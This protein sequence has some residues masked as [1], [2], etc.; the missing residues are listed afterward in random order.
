[1]KQYFRLVPVIVSSL[2]VCTAHSG[3]IP[4]TD[5]PVSFVGPTLEARLTNRLVEDKAYSLEGEAASRNLRVSG[6]Y[7]WKLTEC[8][9]LKITA[10]YLWQNIAY[11][12]FSGNSDVW[13]NQL[14]AGF[15]Y[16][17]DLSNS[18]M[19]P[20]LGL[21]AYI[22]HVPSKSLGSTLGSYVNS[23]G[24][25]LFF[26]DARRVAGSNA[27]GISP[28]Y[29]LG[30]WQGS[31]L[32]VALNYDK[33]YYNTKYAVNDEDTAGFGA[34]LEF[35]QVFGRYLAAGFMAA[36]RQP[37]NNYDINLT[38]TRL[39]YLDAWT[40]GLF[41]DYVVGKNT[42]PNTYDIGITANYYLD[43]SRDD[44][45]C[46]NGSY[47]R[48]GRSRAFVNDKMLAAAA[49]PAVYM[50]QVLAIPDNRTMLV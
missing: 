37:F 30:F 40:I 1:M 49:V 31:R 4:N 43:Q 42:M 3:T 15:D 9:R 44:S 12:Y 14:A 33:V 26:D 25:P 39:P 38:F 13:V 45:I 27:G 46:N 17:I 7:A 5:H 34:T 32:T 35:S 21:N 20:Q 6:T 29:A 10:E 19:Y 24:M 22:S 50:P 18:F 41:G 16:Q 11:P 2:L 47:C 8:Q 23:H 48:Q 36:V 28:Y